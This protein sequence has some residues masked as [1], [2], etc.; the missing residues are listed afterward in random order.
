MADWWESD[1]VAKPEAGGD[2]WKGDP[3][4]EAKPMTAAAYAAGLGQVGSDLP[5]IGPATRKFNAAVSAAVAPLVGDKDVSEPTFLERYQHILGQQEK[6]LE[7]MRQQYPVASGLANLGGTLAASIPF[8]GS[9]LL[10]GGATSFVGQLGRGLASGGAISATDAALRGENPVTAGLTGAALGAAAPAVVRAIAPALPVAKAV[11]PT[12]DEL[13][14]S[15]RAGYAHPEV[16]GVEI[17]PQAVSN[18]SAQI[19]N[20]LVK[21]GFRPITTPKAF[22]LVDELNV[23][24]GVKSVNMADIDSAQKALRN[25]AKEVDAVG[26]PT[27]DAAAASKALRRIDGF[28]DNLA[29][30]D[31]LAGDASKAVPILRAAGKDWGAAMRAEDI[32]VRL[33][34]AERQ[35]AKSGS[36]SNIQ[37]AIKQKVSAVLDVPQ[38]SAGY[39]A[40]ENAAAE[41]VVRGNFTENALRKFGKL[42]FNDGLSLLLHAGATAPMGGVNLPIGLAA[43]G[44][45][46]LAER[47]TSAKAN[48]LEEMLRQ[49]SPLYQGR[50]ATMNLPALMGQQGQSALQALLR[51]QSLRG[52]SPLPL[53]QSTPLYFP[54]GP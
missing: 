43:T 45:R 8:G 40:A 50:A 21:D 53:Q 24:V 34:R 6:P 11:T 26:R 30:P 54:P 36:G 42:G 25:V 1:P 46:K 13:K 49:R 15:A 33:T 52:A 3:V 10:G 14:A 5:I 27:A 17:R 41:A 37:N 44:A 12:V 18:L 31:L 9:P 47:M 48:R 23:P 28:L 39:S 29:Q 20:D 19:Q 35:A 22:S 4:A 32:G 2:F 7:A 16:A 38:R 51:A